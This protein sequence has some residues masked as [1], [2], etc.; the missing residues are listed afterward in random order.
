MKKDNHRRGNT[1]SERNRQP[2][3]KNNSLRLTPKSRTLAGR[4]WS[5]I[6]SDRPTM[7]LEVDQES[8]REEKWVVPWSDSDSENP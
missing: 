1:N 3:T 2:T 5:N 7:C 4:Y 8:D 6:P